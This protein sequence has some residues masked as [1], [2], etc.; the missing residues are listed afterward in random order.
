M[1][2]AAADA[3]NVC[4]LLV[5]RLPDYPAYPILVGV[6]SGAG[7]AA[8]LFR[9]SIQDVEPGRARHSIVIVQRPPRVGCC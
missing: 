7:P 4:G 3:V 2:A 8:S 6:P 9:V 1:L 5:H